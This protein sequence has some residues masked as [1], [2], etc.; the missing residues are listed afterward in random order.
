M[1]PLRH[2]RALAG[3]VALL[4]PPAAAAENVILVDHGT[5]VT[6]A[7]GFI[8]ATIAKST[9]HCI[10][11][12]PL[13]AGNLLANGGRIYFDANGSISNNPSA[14]HTF[15]ASEFRVVTNTPQRVE[16]ALTDTNLSGFNASLH[17]SLRSGDSGFHIFAVF[18]HGPGDP[19]AM[20]EQSRVVIRCD[21]D[22][23]VRAYASSNKTGQMIAPSLLASS[24]MIADATYQLPSG[25]GYTNETGFTVDGFPVYTKYD[26]AEYTEHHRIEGVSGN[27]IGLWMLFGGREYFNGGPTRANVIVHGTETTPVLLWDFHA[28]HFGGARIHKS[29]GEV[30]SKLYGPCFVY[31]NSGTNALRLWEDASARA[32]HEEEAWPY[33]W[34][35]ETNYAIGRETVSGRLHVAGE[36]CSN[37]LVV[38]A[39]S[40]ATNWHMQSEGY[41]FWTRAAADGSFRVPKVR[42]GSYHL[43]AVSPGIVGRFERPNVAVVEEQ[44]TALGVLEWNPPRRQQRLWR[45][46]VPDLSAREFRFGNLPRQFGLWWRYMDE[47]GTND[48]VYRIGTNTAED[49]YYAQA[50]VGMED[51]SWF[52][53]VWRIEFVLTNLPPAPAV[54]TI[55][56]AGGNNGSLI[57]TVNGHQL[58]LIAVWNDSSIVRSATQSGAPRHHELSFSPN[59]LIAGTNVITFRMSKSSMPWIGTRPAILNRGV[60]WDCIQ[61][62]A[63]PLLNEARPRVDGMR[64]EQG[65]VEFRG[66]GG[67][68]EAVWH[69]FAS[70]NLAQW[71]FVDEGRFGTSGEFSFTADI[72]AFERRFFR[73]TIP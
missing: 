43:F 57:T 29:Y 33:D 65:T 16:I 40:G 48:L 36:S 53:P 13:G 42:P 49:W 15:D 7:N 18:R 60:M 39:P 46:G 14:Y 12:R 20:L 25:S 10:D 28:Q 1:K 67:Y 19:P 6:L 63:G 34:M 51:G 45:I 37:A 50:V 5:S 41:Q 66:T 72:A 56:L 68:P 4:L 71:S 31:V 8:S 26:W 58:D 38:L 61:L 55:D 35:V 47:Q 64:V 73:L 69:L 2:V 27:T 54:L 23:F 3:V 44:E 30:W 59:L 22:L 32:A 17:Y 11:L 9:G 70:T 21:P 52:S 62:E 24:P